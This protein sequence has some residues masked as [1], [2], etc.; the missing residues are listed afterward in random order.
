MKPLVYAGI[1]D[2]YNWQKPSNTW[3]IFAD[4][5]FKFGFPGKTGAMEDRDWADVKY[6]DFLTHY[7]VSDNKTESAMLIDIN[8]GATFTIF[9]KFLIKPFISYSFM[10]FSFTAS[11]GSFLYPSSDGDH[12]YLTT[13]IDVL[14]YKQT[15]NIIAIGVSF[16]GKFNKYFDIDISLKLSPLIWCEAYDNHV[17]RNLIITE[18]VDGGFFIEPKLLFSYTPIDFFTLS[19]SV[20]YRNIRGSRGDSEYKKQGK[21]LVDIPKNIGGAGYSAFDIGI[22]AK[23]KILKW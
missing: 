10:R 1:D 14:M 11:G 8:A 5:A 16:Y 9:K 20:A 21:I 6:A 15:W 18:S 3:G 19:L 23:F 2:H 17:M 22:F 12:E 4:T 7:S 13:S